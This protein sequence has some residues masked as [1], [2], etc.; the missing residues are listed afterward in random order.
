MVSTDTGRRPRLRHAATRCTPRARR[1]GS[2]ATSSDRTDSHSAQSSHGTA[3]GVIIGGRRALAEV[4][5][6]EVAVDRRSAGALEARKRLC[7]RVRQIE[8]G[9]EPAAGA[10]PSSQSVSHSISPSIDLLRSDQKA[11]SRLH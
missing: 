8:R 9:P 11:P 4:A 2:G 10:R 6:A 3:R 5:V 1:S 7:T